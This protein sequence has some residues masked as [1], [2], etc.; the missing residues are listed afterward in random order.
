MVVYR[1][2]LEDICD[3]GT[4]NLGEAVR[5]T[6]EEEG[7]LTLYDINDGELWKKGPG[8]VRLEVQDNSHVV[9]YRALGDLE[10]VWAT[11]LFMKAGM[12]VR[13]LPPEERTQ[14]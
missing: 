1:Q 14:R 11:E 5:L 9:L 12:L 8:G 6:L 3:T 2:G 4:G 7:F 13:W 10:P